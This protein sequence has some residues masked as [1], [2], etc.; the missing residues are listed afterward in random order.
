MPRYAAIDIGSNSVRLLVADAGPGDIFKV[1]AAER[2]VTRLGESVFRE[3]RLSEQAMDHICTLLARM[4]DTIRKLDCIGA[5]VVATSAVRDAANQNDFLDRA[6]KAVGSRVEIISGLEE[7][8]LIHLGVMARWPHP[9][10]RI[11]IIDIGGGSGELILSMN[12]SRREAFSKPLGAVR[13]TEVFLK[14]DPPEEIEL[15]RLDQFITE[16]LAP[17]LSKIGS[18][19]FD[20]VIGTS[21][22]AAA[23]AC[24]VHRIPRARRDQADRM[25]VTTAQIRR[26]FS[27]LKQRTLA[28]R[29]S[30]PGI[31]PR[32]AEIIL[33]GTAVF[34]RVLETFQASSL[35]YSSAGVKDGIIAD[36]VHRGVGRER[37]L[38]DRDQRRVVELTARKYGVSVPHARQVASLAHRLF[39]LM[40]PLHKLPAE[41]GSLLEA[42]AYLHDT[43]HYIS[44]S[45]HHKHSAYIVANSGMPG[46]TD[47]ERRLI[48][49][50]CRFHRKS[51]PSARNES[52]HLLPPDEKQAI[53]LLLPLL[54]LADSLDRSHS[55][56]V[57]GIACI[58]KPNSVILEVESSAGANLDLWAAEKVAEVFRQV[59]GRT[60]QL[61][62]AKGSDS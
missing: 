26:L 40:H 60:L 21:A 9:T 14:H 8:R 56:Q 54:R 39:E 55:Q 41:N 59:Y 22:S 38:L 51:M 5:R 50:L 32:R 29:R 23:L 58:M 46:F 20:R 33:A 10:G 15:H 7:A 43:G 1:L 57:D 3:G 30:I 48:A 45:A 47:A 28:E 11:L 37:S 36:L 16:K 44:D 17:C 27:Q 6:A 49:M 12:G 18:A 13:L 35:Y 62:R 34:F 53:L 24:A 31:G 25:R 42:A 4:G 19:R 61:T 52:Y 2:A